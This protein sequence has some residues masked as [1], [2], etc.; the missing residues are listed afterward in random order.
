M[1]IEYGVL[2]CLGG[3]GAQLNAD[4]SAALSRATNEWQIAEWLEK[5]PRLRAGVSVP[6]EDAELAAA[7]IDRLG[8]HPGFVQVLLAA[9]TAE[10]LGRRKYW[11]MYEAA[12]RHDLP[13][14]I[15]FGGGARG[16]PDHR[17]RLAVVLHRGS[18]RDGAGVP[19]PGRRAWSSRASS[20]ASPGSGWS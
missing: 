3:A 19:G 4:Y 11:P 7:E 2:N 17:D 6:Y 5:E 12:E 9:R 18:H 13:I 14:G 10:P 16:V 1:G 20:N 8:D 15:H